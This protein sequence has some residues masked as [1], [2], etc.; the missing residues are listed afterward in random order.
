MLFVEVHDIEQIDTRHH[1]NKEKALVD[2][3]KKHKLGKESKRE[4]WKS[5]ISYFIRA[6]LFYQGP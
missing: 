6:C 5:F 1:S 3:L 2:F 4:R